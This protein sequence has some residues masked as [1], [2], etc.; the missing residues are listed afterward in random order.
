MLRQWI[1]VSVAALG[2]ANCATMG[3]PPSCDGYSRR[4]LNRSLWDWERNAP[5]ATPAVAPNV[6]ASAPGPTPLI[7][8]RDVGRGR[9]PPSA[10]VDV[11]SRPV[12]HADVAA[13]YRPCGTEGMRHG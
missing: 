13:S 4:P 6:P 8:K 11:W 5:V 2:L 10:L 3:K 1:C 7:R 12:S 9:N